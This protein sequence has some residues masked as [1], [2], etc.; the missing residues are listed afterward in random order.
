MGCRKMHL[1]SPGTQRESTVRYHDRQRL[2]NKAEYQSSCGPIGDVLNVSDK[3]WSSDVPLKRR[4]VL[5]RMK[6]RV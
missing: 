5:S 1:R 4:S 6:E 2:P 3:G